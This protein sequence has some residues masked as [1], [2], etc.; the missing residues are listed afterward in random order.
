MEVPVR[1]LSAPD[2]AHFCNASL[3]ILQVN[4]GFCLSVFSQ[5]Y[6]PPFPIGQGM[7][8]L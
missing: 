4:S 6:G 7:A 2:H 8:L 3:P 1:Y 5:P